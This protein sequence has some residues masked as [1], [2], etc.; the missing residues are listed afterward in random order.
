[1]SLVLWIDQNTFSSSLVEKVFKKRGLSFYSLGQVHDFSY[2]VDD[3]KPA[4]IVLDGET[5]AGHPEAFKGQYQQS[6][7]MQTT[8]FIFLE[9]RGDMSFIQ[10]KIGEISK[11]FDPFSIPSVIELFQ[12]VN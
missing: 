12:K 7:V 11:P 2:L 4:V 1:M 3:L 6:V 8:P 9:P 5:F 10:T